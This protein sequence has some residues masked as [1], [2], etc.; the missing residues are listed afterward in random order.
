MGDSIASAVSA[1]F[2]EPAQCLFG[3]STYEKD[4]A[5]ARQGVPFALTQDI[6]EFVTSLDLWAKAY[7]EKESERL[8][9][10]ALTTEQVEAAYNSC[11]KTS[12]KGSLLKLKINMPN[13]AKPCRFWNA[14]GSQ[15][16]WPLDW[17]IDFKLKL[18]ISHLWIMG[19]GPRA[20]FGLVCLLEDC[21]PRK[22]VHA[23]PFGNP[24]CMDE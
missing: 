14:D 16:E 24:N 9:G 15:A 18:K 1:T 19:S 3:P 6:S 12:P 2:K 5:A 4:E 11:I 10:K 22:Q 23:F 21:M 17:G 8:L 13:S 20:E 7:I